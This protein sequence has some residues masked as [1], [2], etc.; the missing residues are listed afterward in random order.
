MTVMMMMITIIINS[1]CNH[2]SCSI[3][4][5]VQGYRHWRNI[6]HI[7]LTAAQEKHKKV[8]KGW[9]GGCHQSRKWTPMAAPSL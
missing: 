5:D 2:C 8:K 3:L 6:N 4:Q 7:F 9:G 1:F